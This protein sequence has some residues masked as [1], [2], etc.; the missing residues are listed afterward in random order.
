MVKVREAL[1]QDGCPVCRVAAE[2][3]HRY[4]TGFLYEQVT[5]PFVREELLQSRGFCVHHAWMLT[6]FYD[7]LGVA[8]VYQ[9]LL[10]ELIRD[11]TAIAQGAGRHKD[12]RGDSIGT[13]VRAALRSSRPCLACQI[14]DQAEE[15]TLVALLARLD[16]DEVRASLS[17]ESA[18]CL[19]H[20]IRAAGLVQHSRQM[21]QL[22]A[23]TAAMLETVR[24][25]LDELIRKHDYRFRDERVT[26]EEGVSW[27]HAIEALVGRDPLED[28]LKKH[29]LG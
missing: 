18:L 20:V 13:R 1:R 14:V 11:Y 26:P 25:R 7:T 21:R 29:S 19:P 2:S 12:R 22:A 9:H 28:R 10:Q 4:L 6:Q 5:D 15:R 23:A 3:A 24:G 17:G 27:I 8:I 16:D